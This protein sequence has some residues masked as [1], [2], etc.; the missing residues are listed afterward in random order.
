MTNDLVFEA[1]STYIATRCPSWCTLPPMHP[2]ADGE[3]DGIGWRTHDTNSWGKYLWGF[4][5]E[6][7]DEPGTVY[8]GISLSTDGDSDDGNY[9]MS[10]LDLERLVRHTEEARAWLA[11]ALREE[12]VKPL[13]ARR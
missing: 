12:N 5:R 8:V 13:E 4:G 9:A 10:H 1:T 11:A 3:A 2:V 7:E 6:Y